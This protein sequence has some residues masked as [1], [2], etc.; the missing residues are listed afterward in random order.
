MQTGASLSPGRTPQL[1]GWPHRNR[2]RMKVLFVHQN[3]PGQ[4]IHILR[5]MARQGGHQLVA[6]GIHLDANTPLPDGVRF[7]RYRIP[8]GN[9]PGLH[10]WLLDTDSKLIR[11]EACARA[12]HKLQQQGFHPDLICAH[13]GWGES[14]L[15]QDIWPD[16]PILHYQEFFYQ[17][18]GFDV[19]F[20]PEFQDTQSWEQRARIRMKNLY[21]HSALQ[22]SRWNV[23]PTDFQRS[24]F[25]AQWQEHFSVIHDGIDTDRTAPAAA[26]V[27]RLPDGTELSPGEPIVTFVNRRLEPY[28]GG[29][30]FLR[31]IPE[32]QRLMP[33]ARVVVIGGTSG[34]SYGRK[35]EQGEWKDVLLAEIHGRYDPSRLHF[36]GSVA[37]PDFL[38][39]LQLSACH[40]YLTYPFVLSWSLLEA[41][42]MARPIVGSDTAPVREVIRDG[43]NGL[44]VDFFRPDALAAAIAEL[45]RQ[46][47]RAEAL[48][49]AARDTVLRHYSLNDCLPR[50]LAL[51]Q[52][53]AN[54]DLGR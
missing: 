27:K 23:T 16:V 15:L 31:A 36:S 46:R 41:M 12:A 14:L 49:Q 47:P 40:V 33:D 38:A 4:Y 54:G 11:A 24:S 22:S 53:V 44:L 5:A 19:D 32:L 21:L 7:L 42:S 20:D 6:L 8:R 43:H 51:M 26:A 34:V 13:P 3:F 39:L 2:L 48:G 52:L 45:L 9:P 28:R 17:A 18:H 37:Y 50:H 30:T 25:P 29:H 35:P 1:A 10:A